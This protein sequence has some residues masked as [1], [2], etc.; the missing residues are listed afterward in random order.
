MPLAGISAWRAGFFRRGSGAA[1]ARLG[2][3]AVLASA[4]AIAR[5]I[6]LDAARSEAV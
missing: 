4:T 6:G 5:V 1:G 2:G 3:G